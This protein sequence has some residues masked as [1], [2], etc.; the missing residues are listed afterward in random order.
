MSDE[1]R[2]LAD[3]GG[4]AELWDEIASTSPE[5]WFWATRAMHDFRMA[6]MEVSGYLIADRSFAFIR[7]GRACGLVPLV[8]GSDRQ[9]GDIAASY[10][11]APLPWPMIAAGVPDR[12]G[13]ELVLFDELEKRVRLAK[14]AML[15]LTL[16]PPGLGVE[17]AAP[18]AR[19]VRDRGFVDTSYLSHWVEVSSDTLR[20]VRARYRQYVRKFWDQYDLAVLAAQ[21]IPEDFAQTYMDLHVKDAGRVSRPL[22]TYERQVDMARR[23]EGFWVTARNKATDRIVGI[24]MISVYKGAAYDASVAVDPEYQDDQIS[25]LM[26]WKTIQHLLELGVQHYELGI[27]AFA[28]S[29]LWQPSEKNYGI[30]FFKDGWSRGRKKTVWVAEKFY[31]RDSFD[32]FWERKRQ[33]ILEHFSI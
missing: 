31:S 33:A 4:A 23:G 11:D 8:L 16:A 9:D 22:V 28:P 30:S 27:D 14:A 7:D 21:D 29:Y 13:I 24:L 12:K 15:R 1:I 2:D 10:M 20:T 25:N 26:K 5:G 18:F 6:Y 32:R 19:I 17:M 3:A